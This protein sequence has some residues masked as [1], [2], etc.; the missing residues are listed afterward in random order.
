MAVTSGISLPAIA[1]YTATLQSPVV[2]SL[3][4]LVIPNRAFRLAGFSISAIS[5]YIWSVVHTT[6]AI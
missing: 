4:S 6:V 1:W 5:S 2:L 3:G